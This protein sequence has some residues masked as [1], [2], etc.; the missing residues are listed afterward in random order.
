MMVDG[1]LDSDTD[2][3]DGQGFWS[4]KSIMFFGMGFGATGTIMAYYEFGTIVSTIIGIISG[5]IF[6]LFGLYI[7]R[8]FRK[9]EA[10]T[11]TDLKD[12]IGSSALVVM[13]IESQTNPGMIAARDAF[14]RT[15]YLNA[16]SST[17]ESIPTGAK[18]KIIGIH[19][20]S[21]IVE[22]IQ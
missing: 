7:L 5:S 9:A 14:D 22:R 6:I 12:I 16:Y 17:K 3:N 21:A 15:V 13:T 18:S 20:Q 4:V 11:T 1:I 2:L 19:G 10:T 8:L